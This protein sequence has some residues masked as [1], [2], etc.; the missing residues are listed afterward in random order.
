MNK[1]LWIVALTLLVAT[2]AFTQTEAD[3]KVEVTDDGEG[4]VIIGYTG[5]VAAV[6]IPATIQGMP[7]REIGRAAFYRNTIITS[8]VI[9]QGVTKIGVA[10]SFWE[11]MCAFSECPKLVSVTIPDGVTEIGDNAFAYSPLSSIKLPE[12]L[13]SLGT[14]ALANTNISSITIPGD[15]ESIGTAIVSEC[16][17]LKTVTLPENL[18]FIPTNM[19]RGCTALTTIVLLDSVYLIQDGA[20]ESSGLT[21]FTL[22][23]SIKKIGSRAFAD[24]KALTTVTIP[25]S[26]ETLE[27]VQYPHDSSG[28]FFGCSKLPL[29]TQA[30]LKKRGYTGKF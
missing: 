13:K 9:P 8:V 27:F 17:N 3:F 6:R 12:S 1:K 15:L 10:S 16:K 22:P 30:A 29:A 2:T 4:V 19:F 20:F 14:S 21:T 25:D 7:V 26:V 24:C 18:K 5:K 28:V 11:G 23:A